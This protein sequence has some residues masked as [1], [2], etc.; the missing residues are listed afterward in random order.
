MRTE[1]RMTGS[2]YEAIKHDLARSHPFASERVGFVAGKMGSLPDNGKMVLLT[3]YHPI[4]DVQYEEDN[5]VG[6]RIGSEAL[7]AAM[8]TVY[9]G[10]AAREGIFHIHL[11]DHKGET[12]MSTVDSRELPPMMPGFQAAGRDAAHGIIILSRNHGSAWVWFP[13]HDEPTRVDKII[14]TGAPVGV[15][16]RRST[17]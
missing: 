3:R 14:V 10:R 15:F 7:T 1:L 11:H 2:L 16:E 12:G 6:A 5:T 9:H 4:P 8:Q 17:T 13:D